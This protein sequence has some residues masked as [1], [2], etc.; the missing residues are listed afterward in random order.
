MPCSSLIQG[1]NI[2]TP[3]T[4]DIKSVNIFNTKDNLILALVARVLT[5]LN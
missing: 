5:T 4:N 3:S 1:Q 2:L